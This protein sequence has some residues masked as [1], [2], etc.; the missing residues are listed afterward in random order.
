MAQIW[1]CL[2]HTVIF[3]SNVPTPASVK[4]NW[5]WTWTEIVVTAAL[6]ITKEKFYGFWQTDIVEF[7]SMKEKCWRQNLT[8]T[9]LICQQPLIQRNCSELGHKEWLAPSTTLPPNMARGIR[10]TV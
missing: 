7:T 6:K 5:S 8:T 9:S 10:R 2:H 3:I 4:I 1:L